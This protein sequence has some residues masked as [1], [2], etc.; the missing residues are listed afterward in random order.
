VYSA[1]FYKPDND[2]GINKK[3]NA[4]NFYPQENNN[5]ELNPEVQEDKTV[6]KN[7]KIYI[8]DKNGKVRSVNRTCTVKEG[9]SCFEFAIAQLLKAP[10]KWEKSKNFTS[11]IPSETKILSVRESSNS[12]MIDLSKDFEYGGGT[13]STF[14]RVIQLIKTANANTNKPVYLFINGKQVNVIGGDGIMI[15]QPLNES[16]ING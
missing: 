14:L 3:P 7:V 1:F 8:L 9:E 15:K 12:I 2:N 10:S 13:E 4:E 16:S 11:E 6:T 5:N